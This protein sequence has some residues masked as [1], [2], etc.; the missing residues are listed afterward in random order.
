M[1][2]KFEYTDYRGTE[3]T[4]LFND[5]SHL[6]TFIRGVEFEGIDFES[7]EVCETSRI[8]DR[9][10]VWQN[11]LCD[12]VIN[13]EIPI[14]IQTIDNL[15]DTTLRIEYTLGKPQSDGKS[16]DEYSLIISLQY[17]NATYTGDTKSGYFED[18]INRIQAQLPGNVF[19]RC[20][21]NCMFSDYSPYGGGSFGSMLC[22]KNHKEEYVKVRCKADLW[23]IHDDF[24]KQVQE[25]YIC[26][27]FLRRVKG[28]GY[29][30]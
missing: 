23:A 9:I 2:W 16:L 7:L 8:T 27:E 12:C 28:I 4:E 13:C 21:L 1:K 24:D 11:Q 3:F 25:T 10:T 29:R 20:C 17:D 18:E 19:I 22:F 15:V 30:G 6:K 14:Q 5:G 26:G